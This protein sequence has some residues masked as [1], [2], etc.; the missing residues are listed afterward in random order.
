MIC[1]SVAALLWLLKLT[2]GR[3]DLVVGRTS[4]R[5]SRRYRPLSGRKRVRVTPLSGGALDEL[6]RLAPS[7]VKGSS[8]WAVNE[9]VP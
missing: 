8:R 2:C 1:G 5:F 7:S 4:I 9:K 6:P 3:Y